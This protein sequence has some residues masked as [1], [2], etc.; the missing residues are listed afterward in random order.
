MG[1]VS[2]FTLTPTG[3]KSHVRSSVA[4]A[5][6]KPGI[7]SGGPVKKPLLKKATA[8]HTTAPDPLGVAAGNGK[9]RDQQDSEFEEF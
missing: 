4:P 7:I 1:L 6:H 8:V 2:S 3:Q 5:L 9:D